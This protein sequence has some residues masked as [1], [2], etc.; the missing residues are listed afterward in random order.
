MSA[1][2]LAE[3]THFSV[4]ELLLMCGCFGARIVGLERTFRNVVV[5]WTMQPSGVV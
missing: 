1:V 4:R 2:G 5:F 3:T